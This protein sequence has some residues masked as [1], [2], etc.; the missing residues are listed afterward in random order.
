MKT[1][2]AALLAVGVALVGLP[3]SGQPASVTAWTLTAPG[4]SFAPTPEAHI[5]L[6]QGKL[7][8]SVTRGATTVLEPSALGV[9]TESGDLTRGLATTGSA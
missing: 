8:L 9:E 1:L 5:A 2:P 3:A 4:T 7:T 6:D